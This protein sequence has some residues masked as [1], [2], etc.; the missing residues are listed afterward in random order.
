[1]VV[2]TRPPASRTAPAAPGGTRGRLRG[3]RSRAGWAKAPLHLLAIT[4]IVP[5]YW[6]VI[7]AFKPVSE[8]TRN[9]PS[10]VP[11]SPTTVGY[12]DPR[13]R[14]DADNPGHVAGLFQRFTEVDLGFWRFAVNSVVIATVITVLALLAAS[15]A[16]YVITKHDIRGRRVIFLMI[17]GSMMIPW[18]ATLVPNYLVVRNLGWVDSYLGYIVPAIPKA[19][20]VFFL[21]QYL[22]SI[23]DDLIEAARIDGAGEWRIWWQVVMPLLRPALAA[24][25]IFVM[26][27]EWNNFLWPLIIVESDQ[28]ANLP[29]ALARLNSAFTGAQ[30]MG[31]IMAASLLASLPTVVFFL[32][33]QKHFTRGI[34][35]SGLKG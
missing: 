3:R 14:P 1:M 18:Q 9:P 21:V 32:L 12:H 30:H 27:N 25:S 17:L 6:M 4:M 5:F 29:V 20:V 24:M 31:V 16:A 8:I 33:F 26:L 23:P 19:F 35:M 13:W 7:T 34:A 22:R 10:F 28:M 11:E 15:L 2:R